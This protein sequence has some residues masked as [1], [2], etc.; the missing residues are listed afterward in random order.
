MGQTNIQQNVSQ[1]RKWGVFKALRR[2][3]DE[4]FAD[5]NDVP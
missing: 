2:L 1:C 4:I 5:E 3:R